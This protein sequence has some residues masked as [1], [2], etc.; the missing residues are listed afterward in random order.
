[1]SAV[2]HTATGCRA[3]DNGES[4]ERALAPVTGGRS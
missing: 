4:L 1:M 2:A 3:R